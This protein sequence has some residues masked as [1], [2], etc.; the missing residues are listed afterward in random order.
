M[1]LNDGRVVIVLAILLILAVALAFF[2]L[3]GSP[4]GLPS[5]GRQAAPGS[6]A[7]AAWYDLYFT[8]PTYPDRPENRRG[9]IDERLVAYID[10]A[11]GLPVI[12]NGGDI[13]ITWD[14]G[15][16]RIFAL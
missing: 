10:S 8:T 12:P 9:G 3:R 2:L 11:T 4:T 6:P 7:P 5:A 13:T 15:A 16:N 1:R 14:S